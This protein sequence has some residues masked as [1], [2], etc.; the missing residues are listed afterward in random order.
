VNKVQ[1]T[2]FFAA[3][4]FTL[5]GVMPA[6]AATPASSAPMT[7]R[8]ADPAQPDITGVWV[9]GAFSFAAA[10]VVAKTLGPEGTRA[11]RAKGVGLFTPL[12]WLVRRRVVDLSY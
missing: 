1:S 5:T 3:V 4:M 9:L 7:A 12:Q 8:Y 6:I 10:G 2:A 11:L